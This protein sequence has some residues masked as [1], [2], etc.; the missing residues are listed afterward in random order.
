MENPPGWLE[1]RVSPPIDNPALQ[2]LDDGEKAAIA[3]SLALKA[4]L[5]LME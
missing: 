1:V 3:L 4:D 2:P 5:V